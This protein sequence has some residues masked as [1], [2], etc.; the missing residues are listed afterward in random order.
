MPTPLD[1]ALHS[2]NSFL[3]FGGLV[4]AAAVW[5]I[6]G[7]DMFPKE[8]DPTGGMRIWAILVVGLVTLVAYKVVFQI[9][10]PGRRRS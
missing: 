2:K 6:W 5:S 7:Q 3:A 4:T 9:L 1:R 10:K 8:T